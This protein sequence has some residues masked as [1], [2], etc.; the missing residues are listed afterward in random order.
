MNTSKIVM[1]LFLCALGLGEGCRTSYDEQLAQQ[2]MGA[3]WRLAENP[4]PSLVSNVTGMAADKH[5][6]ASTNKQINVFK[7]RQGQFLFEFSCYH[8]N[9]G[10]SSFRVYD[11]RTSEILSYGMDV[12][13]D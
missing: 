13:A 12:D 2:V 1:S 4:S 5:W 3:P 6:Q 7:N 8:D 11:P 9:G 10:H